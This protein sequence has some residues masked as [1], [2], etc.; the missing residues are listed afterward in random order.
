MPLNTFKFLYLTK[1]KTMQ[2]LNSFNKVKRG[3]FN[4]FKIN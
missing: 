2:I 1:H 3:K 4:I